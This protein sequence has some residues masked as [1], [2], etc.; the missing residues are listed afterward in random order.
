M[1][2]SIAHPSTFRSWAH[3]GDIET[4]VVS[5]YSAHPSP[6]RR[7]KLEFASRRMAL[8]LYCCGIDADDYVGRNVLDAG[9]GTGEYACWFAAHGSQVTGIDLSD[10]SLSEARA[11][12]RQEGL[13]NVVFET[14]SVLDTRLPSDSYD[15]VYCTGVLHH[16]EN[17]YSGLREL[18][19]VLRPGGKILISLYNAVGFLPREARRRIARRLGG[20][21]L[22]RRVI[23]GQRLFPLLSRRLTRASLN[24]PA[25]ALY[26]YFAI[27]HQS[28][29]TIGQVLKWF[30]R[31]GLEYLGSF[32]P[33]VPLDYPAMLTHESFS[34]VDEEYRRPLVRLAAK[35]SP[36][37]ALQRRRPGL[38]S[39]AAIQLLWLATGVDIWSTAGRK[40][41]GGPALAAGRGSSSTR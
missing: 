22:K 7:D 34:S 30:D 19:R 35:M 33:A 3:G 17:S 21:D 32:P 40:D 28:L 26:D 9:C 2:R 23:W 16:I 15:L 25:S 10:G 4:A 24:D 38:S 37:G 12:A 5:M 1:S 11:Y 41:V 20:K 14:R 18:T 6:S 31:L 8:R 13:R 36:G 27:P 39:R 29:H